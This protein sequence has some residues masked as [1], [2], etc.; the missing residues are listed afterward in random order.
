[1]SVVFI[2]E[3]GMHATRSASAIVETCSEMH[4]LCISIR[5]IRSFVFFPV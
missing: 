3:L 2:A 1:M 5:T 4:R